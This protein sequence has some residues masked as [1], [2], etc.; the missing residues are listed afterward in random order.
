[1]A[2]VSTDWETYYLVLDIEEES[3]LVWFD[4]MCLHSNCITIPHAAELFNT[5]Q[6]HMGQPYKI[7]TVAYIQVCCDRQG[8]CSAMEALDL[9]EMEATCFCLRTGKGKGAESLF[10]VQ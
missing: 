4:D 10:F 1:M 6:K 7:G 5:L 9:A 2:I 8:D 3:V